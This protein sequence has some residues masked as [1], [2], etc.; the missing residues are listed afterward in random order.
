MIA[1]V[2]FPII[3]IFIQKTDQM[4]LIVFSLLISVIVIITH[5]KNIVRLM[6]NEESK[7]SFKSKKQDLQ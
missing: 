3:I 5:R 2:T 1:A 4:S 7:I 6:K